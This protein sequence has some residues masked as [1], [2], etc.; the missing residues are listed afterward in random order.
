MPTTTITGAPF[1]YRTKE[2]DVLDA[3]CWRMYGRQEGAV[4]FVLAKNAGV[5]QYPPILPAGIL[6]YFWPLA[7]TISR[8]TTVRLYD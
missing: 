1:E 4:E 6:V 2:G 5:A 3:L 8:K 7:Q